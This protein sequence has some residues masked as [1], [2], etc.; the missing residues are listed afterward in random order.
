MIRPR[1]SPRL[2]LAALALLPVLGGLTYQPPAATA[3]S[4]AA[5]Y[6]NRNSNDGDHEVHRETCRYLPAERNR[7]YLGEFSDCHDALEAARRHYRTA[8]GC[9]HCARACDTG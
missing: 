9:Y 2:L 4:T 3:D 8:D 6:V 5:Y 7:I 1:S